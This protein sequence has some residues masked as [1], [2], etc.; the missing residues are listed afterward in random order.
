MSDSEEPGPEMDKLVAKAMG[1]TWRE[2]PT[3]SH[4]ASAAD[5]MQGSRWFDGE[6]DTKLDC[7]WKPSTNDGHALE[8]LKHFHA[9]G[10]PVVLQDSNLPG[11]WRCG[12]GGDHVPQGGRTIALA[13]CREVLD[14][15]PVK[16]SGIKET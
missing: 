9:K 10:W 3:P 7:M 11:R 1:W 5:G 4:Y 8:V 12:I 14:L 6:R 13:I 16:Q 2:F 15:R